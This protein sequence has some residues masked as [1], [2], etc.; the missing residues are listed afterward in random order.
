[1]SIFAS[2]ITEKVELPSLDLVVVIRKLS[3]SSLRKA[4]E[5]RTIGDMQRTRNI[6]SDVLRMFDEL[7]KERDKSIAITALTLE[8]KRKARYERYDRDDLLVRGVKEWSK[9]DPL[10]TENLL[11]LPEAEAQTVFERIV[12]LA[13]GV[14]TEEEADAGKAQASSPSPE[15]LTT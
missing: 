12:D 6:G 4:R 5:V 1:M 2:Q 15:S 3:G 7:A 11:D 9:T 8:Q 10:T 13:E 14:L